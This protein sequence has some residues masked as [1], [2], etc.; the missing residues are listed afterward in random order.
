MWTDAASMRERVDTL[1]A[2]R[3]E[4][5][6]LKSKVLA[7]DVIEERLQTLRDGLP[8]IEMRFSHKS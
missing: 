3:A 5:E 4:V 7:A 6:R 1:R 8:K 2:A